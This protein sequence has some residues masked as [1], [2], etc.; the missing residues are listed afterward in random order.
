VTLFS[1]TAV[2]D[3]F[4]GLTALPSGWSVEWVVSRPTLTLLIDVSYGLHR[5]IIMMLA[6]FILPL[7]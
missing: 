4:A 5:D 2:E 1:G 3:M 6:I 7:Q